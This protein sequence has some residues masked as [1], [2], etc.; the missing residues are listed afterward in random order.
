MYDQFNGNPSWYYPAQPVQNPYHWR[1]LASTQH[2]PLQAPTPVRVWRMP[3]EH[4][5]TFQDYGPQPF[6]IDIEDAAEENTNYRNALWTGRHLQ[7]T[8]MSIP[9]GGDIGLEMHPNT[10]QFLRI[11]DGHG[12]V[13]MGS[14][15]DSVQLQRRVED[16]DVILVP[17][18]TWHNLINT[19]NE[20]LKLYSIYAPPEHPH[21]TVHRTKAEAM[22][23][24]AAVTQGG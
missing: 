8:L 20:P 9:V 16:G 24:E 6:T 12:V 22:A 7:L 3:S 15:Q 10:D 1:N 2:Y 21:G 11:E 14:S 17:A 4:R 23:A 18:G 19:G 5:I 13:R